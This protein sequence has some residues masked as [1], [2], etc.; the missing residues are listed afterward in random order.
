MCNNGGRVTR[1]TAV[2]VTAMSPSFY[3]TENITLKKFTTEKQVLV[4]ATSIFNK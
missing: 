1:A 2:W 4:E 3:I